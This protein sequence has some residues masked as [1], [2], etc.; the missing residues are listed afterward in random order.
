MARRPEN[1][2]MKG[3]KLAI[4]IKPGFRRTGPAGLMNIAVAAAVGVVSGHYIFKQPL[5]DY[6]TEKRLQ[7]ANALKNP[8]AATPSQPPAAAAAEKG[9]T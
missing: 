9:T 2:Y 3:F 8:G 6:W 7:E 1:A 5:E 4:G